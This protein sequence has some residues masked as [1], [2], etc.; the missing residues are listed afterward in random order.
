MSRIKRGQTLYYQPDNAV[1]ISSMRVN[2]EW[3]A[4]TE[5]ERESVLA[6][7]SLGEV[8]TKLVES[9][10]IEPFGLEQLFGRVS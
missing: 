6:G 9:T 4:F 2:G 5:A 3:V 8:L 7:A 10:Q 1:R